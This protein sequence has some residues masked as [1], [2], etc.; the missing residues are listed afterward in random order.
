MSIFCEMI[1]GYVV[2]SASWFDSGYTSFPVY[3]GFSTNFLFLSVV[4]RILRSILVLLTCSVFVAKSTGKLDFLVPR[5]CRQR[6]LYALG[7]F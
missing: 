5:S 4:T 2:F 1:S 7:W 6:Q 3:R